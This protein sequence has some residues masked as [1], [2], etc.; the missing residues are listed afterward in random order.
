MGRASMSSVYKVTMILSKP[1]GVGLHFRTRTND[2]RIPAQDH[3]S[4][5]GNA[6]GIQGKVEPGAPP[7]QLARRGQAQRAHH[8]EEKSD[9]EK[10]LQHSRRF[11]S[12]ATRGDRHRQG[13]TCRPRRIIHSALLEKQR[14]FRAGQ[15][16]KGNDRSS[17]RGNDNNGK[18]G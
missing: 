4:G 8:R 17:G 10:A 11:S 14:S 15:V 7:V 3:G 2:T 16:E 5:D 13:E 1:F 12:H 9:L 6:A 18:R